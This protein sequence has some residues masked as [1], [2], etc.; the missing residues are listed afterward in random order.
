MKLAIVFIVA[1]VLTAIFGWGAKKGYN[2]DDEN[3]VVIRMAE[4]EQAKLSRIDAPHTVQS[5]TT[6]G[7]REV[8]GEGR[9]RVPTSTKQIV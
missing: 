2:D 3:D 4:R 8:R 7:G 5:N 1:L 9:G 6:R